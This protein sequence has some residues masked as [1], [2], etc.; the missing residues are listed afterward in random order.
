MD[1]LMSEEAATFEAER[2]NAEGRAPSG[3]EAFAD[4]VSGARW[5]ARGVPRGGFLER[6][7]RVTT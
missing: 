3:L 4:R 7:R 2:F 6:R 1:A 5:L